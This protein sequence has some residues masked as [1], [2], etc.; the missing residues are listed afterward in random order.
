MHRPHRLLLLVA[1]ALGCASEGSAPVV[2]IE[3]LPAEH[4]AVLE[5]Y[6]EGGEV[7]EAKRAEVRADPEL[8]R[9]TVD[10]LV[11]EMV[12]AHDA[13]I[14]NVRGRARRAHDRA[15]AELV[16][17]A[18]A[19]TPVLVEL[20]E[21][22]DGIVAELAGETLVEIGEGTPLL[23]APLLDREQLEPRRRAAVLLRLLPHAGRD[24]PE[25]A[26]RLARLCT[27][28]PDWFLR[29]ECAR[30]LGT[31]AGR[32]RDTRAARAVL[33]G[34]L[35]D[36]DPAVAEYAALGLGALDDPRAL[37]ALVSTLE[38]AAGEGEGKLLRST[39]DALRALTGVERDLD[40]AGWRAWWRDHGVEA[41][42]GPH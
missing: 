34:V 24:E 26:S 20:F 30:T 15:R 23:V 39:Q 3:E 9:F 32:G 36:P 22:G 35:R 16:R 21:V 18:P 14:S 11:I 8:L 25:I 12:R 37:P 17:L 29:A 1:L 28:D 4:R 42:G 2:T 33:E 38:R 10:N 6:G 19:S 27:S 41:G 40:V 13:L 7:W 5:A 31:R